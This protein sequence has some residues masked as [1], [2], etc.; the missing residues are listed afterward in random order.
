MKILFMKIFK[1]RRRKST[2]Q[3]HPQM[4]LLPSLAEKV[5]IEIN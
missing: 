4:P 2:E 1:L 5:R 3:I